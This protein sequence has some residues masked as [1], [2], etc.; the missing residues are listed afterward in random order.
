[1]VTP[2]AA[3]P[4]PP[5]SDATGNKVK[6]RAKWTISGK[7]DDEIS[8]KA[9][10]SRPAELYQLLKLILVTFN[11]AIRDRLSTK[12]LTLHSNSLNRSPEGIKH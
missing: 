2:L 1:M 8:Q 6:N 7:V 3:P 11:Q 9:K 5:S 10:L 12:V 4:P